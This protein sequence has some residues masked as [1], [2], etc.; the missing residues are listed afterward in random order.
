MPE[1]YLKRYILERFPRGNVGTMERVQAIDYMVLQ[2]ITN[3]SSSPNNT[4][5]DL[6]GECFGPQL[7]ALSHQEIASRLTLACLPCDPNRWKISLENDKIT[8]LD[9]SGLSFSLCFLES[10]SCL[11]SST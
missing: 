4:P 3:T 9:V 2:V 7:D 1:F 8:L 11:H 10:D 6:T 5:A